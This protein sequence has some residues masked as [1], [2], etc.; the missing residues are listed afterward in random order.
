MTAGYVLT[1]DNS[2]SAT[3]V[4]ELVVQTVD[5]PLLPEVRDEYIDVPGLDG[6]VFYPGSA[7]DRRFSMDYQLV[8]ADRTARRES[9][10]ALA[11]W[12]RKLTPRRLIVDNE[13][14][15]FWEAKLVT[16]NTVLERAAVRGRGSLDWRTGPFAQ[17]VSTSETTALASAAP[18]FPVDTTASDVEIVP[19]IEVTC[20]GS[21]PTGFVLTIGGTALTYGSAVVSLDVK[22]I[23]CVTAT[24]VDGA[25]ADTEFATGSFDGASLDMA[26]VTGSF[27]TL[28]GEGDSTV[29]LA[30]VTG[31]V[32]V[33]WRERYL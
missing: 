25:Y 6:S 32:R 31:D 2:S 21:S 8:A 19:V 26:D 4:P 27:G 28:G 16:S 13:P 10:R 33:V 23:S 7:G 5:R 1:Y 9:V 24:V 20:T 22:T 11:K 17:S 29:Q 15:R 18:D 12:A 30:G 14:D 3:A